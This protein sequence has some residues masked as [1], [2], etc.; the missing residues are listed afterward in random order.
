MKTKYLYLL[1]FLLFFFACEEKTLDPISESKGKPDKVTEVTTE[2]T[3]GGVIISYRIPNNE[4]V[5]GVKAV[6]TI[7]NGRSYESAS[8]YYGNSIEL[9]GYDT[10]KEYE[11]QLYTINRAQELS[12]PVM[13]KFTPLVSPIAQSKGTINIF[14]SFGGIVFVWAN[15]AEYP[16]DYEIFTAT[17]NEA[18]RPVGYVTSKALGDTLI[19]K[20]LPAVPHRFGAVIRDRWGNVS[21]TIFALG[22]KYVIPFIEEKLAKGVMK[23]LVL[24]NDAAFD[25]YEGEY[26]F[27]I[28]D[29]LTTYNHTLPMN[30]N[31]AAFTIDLGRPVKL[32]SFRLFHRQRS[33]DD[34]HAGY[35]Y[36]GNVQKFEFFGCLETPSQSGDWSEWTKLLDCEVKKPS[37]LSGLTMTDADLEL[38]ESGFPFTMPMSDEELVIR[39]VRLRVNTVWGGVNEYIYVAELDFYGQDAN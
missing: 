22:G 20:G 30:V 35:Y 26:E 10:V 37:G 2:S 28:D 34:Q 12:D 32:S 33:S 14:N 25:A 4:D 36:Q 11:A 7:T 1:G 3:P 21:D 27:A 5:L 17:E 18:F 8:S 31:G 9:E 13:V 19:I 39:Y 23:P 15:P 16:L 6:Y 29:N 38:A 24:D